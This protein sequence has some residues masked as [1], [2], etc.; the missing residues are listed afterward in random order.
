MSNKL[1]RA[2]AALARLAQRQ[3]GAV[4]AA[5]LAA[6]EISRATVSEWTRRGRLH[7]LHRGVYAVGHRSPSEYQRYMAAVLAC[8][9]GAALSHQSAAYLWGFLKPDGGPVHVTSPST[10]GKALRAGIVL[11]RS[12]SLGREGE[13]TR[14]ERIPV[15]TPRRTM[16]DLE[17]TIDP[18][19][20]RRAKSQAEF[21]RFRLNLPGDRTRSDLER[22][23]L[24]FLARHGFPRPEVNVKVGRYTVDFLWPSH[25]LAVETDFFD[26]HRGSVAFEDDHQRELDLRR[27]GYVVRRYT[28]AQIR[29][30]PAL[31][32]ADLGEILNIAP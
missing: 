30:H 27:L 16:E 31:V 12:P 3:H 32:V 1:D 24:R 23:F 20:A 21:M 26:Y 11:H 28:G 18:Y 25:M 13:V 9:E 14:R 6:L 22:D 17:S 19:L 5:Q 7:R 10:S 2:E 4:S 29:N 15:T 8:G